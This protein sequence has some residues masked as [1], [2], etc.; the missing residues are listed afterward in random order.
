MG[1]GSLIYVP[2][3]NLHVPNNVGEELG[4]MLVSQMPRS[5]HDRFFEDIDQETK[6]TSAPPVP[7]EPPDMERI[8]NIAAEYGI[9]M[10]SPGRSYNRQEE[11]TE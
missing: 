10:L 11:I 6:D 7:E 4:R 9:E 8:A 3:G 2:K 1:A 5:L